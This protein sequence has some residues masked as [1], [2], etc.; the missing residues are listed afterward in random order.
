MLFK[1]EKLLFITIISLLLGCSNSNLPQ[2]KE[3][4]INQ[5]DNIY[6]KILNSIKNNNLDR[7]GELY[8]TLKE[9]ENSQEI[10][11]S[12]NL[13]AMAHIE[14]K[15][16]ILANFYIQEALSI[17][18]SDE[19]LRYLLV[20][21]QFLAANLNSN[22]TNYINKALKALEENRYLI[23]DS[24]YQILANT[25][26]TRVK[27]DIAWNNKEVG[28]LYKRLS[29]PKAYEI[30]KEKVRNLGFNTKEIIKN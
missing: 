30:Y 12:A 22:D 19:F 13:L 16:Y 11:K 6:T 24:D 7:A 28:N 5:Q 18:S 26:L 8:I 23:S 29:K 14:K 21:N 1:R 2:K 4:T 9:S 15:E 10:K 25:M 3:I 20:K 17:D 27:L